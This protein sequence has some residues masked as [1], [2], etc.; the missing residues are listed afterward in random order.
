MKYNC[1][2]S[3]IKCQDSVWG[4]FY[5]FY[6]LSQKKQY[7]ESFRSSV[8]VW[9]RKRIYG[10]APFY[11]LALSIHSKCISDLLQMKLFPDEG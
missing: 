11:L 1:K 4:I 10:E 6:N 3:F 9:I 7:C 8:H 2:R 5:S